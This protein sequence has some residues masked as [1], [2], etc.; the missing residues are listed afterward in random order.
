[1]RFSGQM[2]HSIRFEFSKCRIQ[3]LRIANIDLSEAVIF[4]RFDGGDVFKARGIG[5]LVNVQDVM[6]CS[7]RLTYHRRANETCTACD[8]NSHDLDLI[9][10]RALEIGK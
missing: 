3:G 8:S 10:E 2:H 5:Q 4:R 9:N 7:H 6:A 1:M